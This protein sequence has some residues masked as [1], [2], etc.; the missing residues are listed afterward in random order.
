ML[1]PPV[2]VVEVISETAAVVRV[3]R[4]SITGIVENVRSLPYAVPA[5][6]VAYAL[7][8]YRVLGV[9]PVMELVNVP[10]PVPSLVQVPPT[11]GLV[12]VLQQTPLAVTSAPPSDVMLPPPVADVLVILEMAVVTTVG[13]IS[14]EGFKK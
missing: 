12:D 3:G 8:W 7:T 11:A 5:E 13:R 10:I 2:A 1:P 6:L 14:T 4:F 9:R